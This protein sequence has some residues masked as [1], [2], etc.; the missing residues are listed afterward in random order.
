MHCRQQLSWLAQPAL[1]EQLPAAVSKGM[2]TS[3]GT[4]SECR[5]QCVPVYLGILALL[6]QSKGPD[7]GPDGGLTCWCQA[8]VTGTR[9]V[10]GLYPSTPKSTQ[11]QWSAPGKLHWVHMG[12]RRLL[13]CPRQGHQHSTE[14]YKVCTPLGWVF[15]YYLPYNPE[16]SSADV[17]HRVQNT[18]PNRQKQQPQSFLFS[19]S[20]GLAHNEIFL[21]SLRPYVR[22]GTLTKCAKKSQRPAGRQVPDT[23]QHHHTVWC[24]TILHWTPPMLRQADSSV[25]QR[26]F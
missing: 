4:C 18:A 11:A 21:T 26:A 15:K 22:R 17:L 24:D 8:Q 10:R 1:P 7:G 14:G 6:K 12:T 25:Q 5:R 3:Q 2:L 16:V 19:A 9:A 20:K 13:L 23:D